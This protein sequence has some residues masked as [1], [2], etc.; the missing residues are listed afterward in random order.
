MKVCHAI[1]EPAQEEGWVVCRIFKK[2]NHHKTPV[3]ESPVVLTSCSMVTAE[4]TRGNQRLAGSIS[5]EEGT[6]EKILQYMGRTCM[7]ETEANQRLTAIFPTPLDSATN[8]SLCDRFMKLPSLESP[9]KSSNTNAHACYE[10]ITIQLPPRGV[11]GDGD[12]TDDACIAL[13][14]MSN[15]V[16]GRDN[17]QTES[18]LS[19]WAV[20]D[21]L[22]ATHLNGQ[23]ETAKQLSSC[24]DCDPTTNST[25]TA[26]PLLCSPGQDLQLQQQ[27]RSMPSSSSNNR[28][29]YHDIR[30]YHSECELWSFAR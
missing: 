2:K 8:S 20:L 16:T 23:N 12:S 22:V 4:S 1:G 28:A 10:P 29:P 9:I 26:V 3:L 14:Q 13:S 24:F 21:R 19:D 5:D 30:D 25:G 27:L 17:Y 18:G 7:E 15:V 11:G 6:L